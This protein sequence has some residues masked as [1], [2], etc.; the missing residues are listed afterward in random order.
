MN[1]PFLFNQGFSFTYLVGLYNN[2]DAY[3]IIL[4]VELELHPPP[5]AIRARCWTTGE[6]ITKQVHFRENKELRR[7][8]IKLSLETHSDGLNTIQG[9]LT[10][11]SFYRQFFFLLH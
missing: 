4:F 8:F 2:G 10:T 11:T 6:V 9:R 1:R 7:A 5:F 3:Y